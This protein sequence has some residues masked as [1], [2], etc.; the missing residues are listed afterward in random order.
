[1]FSWSGS[2]RQAELAMTDRHRSSHSRL[3]PVRPKCSAASVGAAVRLL[4]VVITRTSG[5]TLPVAP[6]AHSSGHRG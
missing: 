3:P 5:R 4:L 6:F 1:M 2:T